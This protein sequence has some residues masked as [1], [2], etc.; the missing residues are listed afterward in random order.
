MQECFT[1]FISREAKHAAER[2]SMGRQID[3]LAGI[4]HRGVFRSHFVT[5][6]GNLQNAWVRVG[7]PIASNMLCTICTTGRLI[8]VEPWDHSDNHD[9]MDTHWFNRSTRL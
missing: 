2:A 6:E 3:N 7:I 5:E 1:L 4:G 8:N 9:A